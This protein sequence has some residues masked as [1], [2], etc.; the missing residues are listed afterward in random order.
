MILVKGKTINIIPNHQKEA[1]KNLL[2][3][4]CIHKNIGTNDGK[5]KIKIW[6]I[7]FLIK[8]RQISTP[9]IPIITG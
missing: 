9:K 5:A 3:G 6:H 1:E 4:I 7:F 8:T 2:P